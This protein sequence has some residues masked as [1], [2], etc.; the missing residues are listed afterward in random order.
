MEFEDL[1]V[2]W[3]SQQDEPLYGVNE[4]GLHNTLR[5]NSKRFRR[6]IFWQHLQT[7][8]GCTIAIT[9][10]V[11]LLLLNASGLLGDIGSSRALHGWEIAGLLISLLCWLQFGASVYLGNRQQKKQEKYDTTSLRDDLDKE[12]NRTKYQIRTRSHIMLG[13]VP[14]YFGSTLWIII[15]FGVSGISYWAI[16]PVIAVMAT[17]LIIESRCQRRFVEQEITPRLQQL[18][19]LRETL[20]TA[21]ASESTIPSETDIQ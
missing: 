15:V 7:F 21:P 17:A 16:V 13:F 18:E 9:A 8:C 6:V 19:T 5:N 4:D 20:I 10:I 12:I 1:Q 2:I 3:N 14:P 11:G